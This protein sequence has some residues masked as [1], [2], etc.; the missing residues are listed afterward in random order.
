MEENKVIERLDDKTTLFN[1]KAIFIL[2]IKMKN[3]KYDI[4]IL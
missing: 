1:S 2:K 3:K 4:K